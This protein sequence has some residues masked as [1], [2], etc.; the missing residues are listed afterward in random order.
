MFTVAANP[1]SDVTS[2]LIVTPFGSAGFWSWALAGRLTRPTTSTLAAA[3][4]HAFVII[5]CAPQE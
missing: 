2:P 5:R 4:M 3:A 1:P